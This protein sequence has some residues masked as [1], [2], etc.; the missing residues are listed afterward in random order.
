MPPIAKI[1]E[2]LRDDYVLSKQPPAVRSDVGYCQG[3]LRSQRLFEGPVPLHGE[4]K[5]QVRIEGV[6]YNVFALIVV[7]NGGGRKAGLFRL[8]GKVGS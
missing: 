5:L 2:L 4:G 6:M 3:L 7:E 1:E 8:N